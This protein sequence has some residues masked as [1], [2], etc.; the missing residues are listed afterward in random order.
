MACG[1]DGCAGPSARYG[2]VTIE[3]GG[4][5]FVPLCWSHYRLLILNEE[6]KREIDSRPR[7]WVVAEASG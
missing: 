3:E 4:R 7:D 6:P 2:S 1:I 5:R